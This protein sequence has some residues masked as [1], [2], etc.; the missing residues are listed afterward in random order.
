MLLIGANTMTQVLIFGGLIG[1]SI[2][3]FL[4]VNWAWA[5]DLIPVEGGGRYLGISNIA[6]A[7]SGVLAAAGGFLLDYFNAQSHNLG[8]TALFISAALCYVIGTGIA[9]AVR[10]TRVS[11][12]RVVPAAVEED[13]LTE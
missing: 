6:T 13:V 2:G 4:S 12:S 9:F 11:R 7:G 8:Y 5:T 10:D 3:M 1:V